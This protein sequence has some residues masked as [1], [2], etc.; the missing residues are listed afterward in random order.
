MRSPEFHSDVL[1]L[2]Y[3]L[4]CQCKDTKTFLPLAAVAV[5]VV[6][7]VAAASTFLATSPLHNERRKQTRQVA[8]M[9]FGLFGD[10]DKKDKGA[11]A[12]P[13]TSSPTRPGFESTPGCT[14]LV[15]GSSGLCG[16]RLVE[17][18]LER[19]AKTVICFDLAAPDDV[20]AKRFEV[21]QEATGGKLI[22]WHGKE[23]NLTS[24]KAVEAAFSKEGVKIDV[25][26]HIAALV[27]PFHDKELYYGV[28][29]EGT[30]R[31]I[32]MCKKYKVP[33]LVYVSLQ[34]DHMK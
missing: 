13:A 33:K 30:M 15:T 26:Y 28:N 34:E 23:G 17:M 21:A 7:A 19:G 25:C 8:T 3:R 12:A 9:V 24:D 11:A 6:I 31:I 27:G 1:C 5:I 2:L 18:L 20:L 4:A 10:N 29:Y 22:F 32:A 16:A 14:A